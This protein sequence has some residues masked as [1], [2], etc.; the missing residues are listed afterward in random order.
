MD[1]QDADLLAADMFVVQHADP[2]NPWEQSKKKKPKKTLISG[3][4]KRKTDEEIT[5]DRSTEV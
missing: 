3:F 2:L 5:E 4:F 1:P